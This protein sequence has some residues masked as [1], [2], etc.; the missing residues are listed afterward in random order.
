M[1]E[2]EHAAQL[3]VVPV[4]MRRDGWEEWVV[5]IAGRVWSI[6]ADSIG[7]H[8]ETRTD[9]ALLCLVDNTRWERRGGEA[10]VSA[11]LQRHQLRLGD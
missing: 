3:T 4:S 10:E 5:C 6:S 9:W 11:F 7:F 8:P 2:T 1:A